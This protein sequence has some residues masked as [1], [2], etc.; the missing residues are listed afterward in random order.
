MAFNS[1]MKPEEPT[2][3]QILTGEWQIVNVIGDGEI[4]L[5]EGAF[6]ENALLHLDRNETFLFINVDGQAYAG[7][8]EADDEQLTLIAKD[9]TIVFNIVYLDFRKLHVYYSFSN[10]V[11]GEIEV[12]YLFNRVQ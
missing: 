1:C 9:N 2:N 4:N 7:E 5:P 8:W 6:T 12:R 3:V 11:T 10:Q